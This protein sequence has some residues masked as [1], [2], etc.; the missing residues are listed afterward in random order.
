M[1]TGLQRIA[2]G[3]DALKVDIIAISYKPFLSLFNMT[4]VAEANPSLAGIGK[5]TQLGPACGAPFRSYD[6][7]PP[8]TSPPP[9]D[10]HAGLL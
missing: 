10:T 5:S 3:S 6:H 1:I 9:T 8:P 7:S 4:G 2:N